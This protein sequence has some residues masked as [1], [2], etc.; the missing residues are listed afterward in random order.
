MHDSNFF[1]DSSRVFNIC[2]LIIRK[3]L[4]VSWGCCN[5]R[6]DQLSKF[7]ENKWVLLWESGCRTVLIGVESGSQKTLD[8]M[9]KDITIE[10]TVKVIATTAKFNIKVYCSFLVGIPWSSDQSACRY[11]VQEEFKITLDFMDKLLGISPRLRIMFFVYLPYPSSDLF[12]KA[13]QL[14]LNLPD[15]LEGWSNYLMA[16]ED[17][18]NIIQHQKWITREQMLETLMISSYIFFFLDPDSIGYI[19]KRVKNPLLRYIGIAA[20][21]FFKVVCGFRWRH[22]WFGMPLDFFFYNF[23]RRHLN[24]G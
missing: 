3:K 8:V 14:G 21:Y 16:A 17:A 24:I 22:R 15:S 9:N 1:V 23:L 19:E 10:Q 12:E 13:A 2:E 4:Q 5:G 6:S 18:R 7:D 20:F 11:D